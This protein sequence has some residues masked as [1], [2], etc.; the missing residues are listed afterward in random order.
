MLDFEFTME[1]KFSFF[2]SVLSKVLNDYLGD[3]GEIL[4]SHEPKGDV[5]TFICLL[6]AKFW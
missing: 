5:T 4:A 6:K 3:Y 2:L 1:G